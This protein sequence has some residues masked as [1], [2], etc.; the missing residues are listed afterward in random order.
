MSPT[1]TLPMK[2]LHPADSNDYHTEQLE[3]LRVKLPVQ[4][5]YKTT[6]IFCSQPQAIVVFSQIIG[7]YMLYCYDAPF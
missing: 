6:V 1:I 5:T 3:R 2:K 4:S 7:T